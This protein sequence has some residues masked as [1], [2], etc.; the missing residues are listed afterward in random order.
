MFYNDLVIISWDHQRFTSL[1]DAHQL[2]T[3]CLLGRHCFTKHHQPFWI[4]CHWTAHFF[5]LFFSFWYLFDLTKFSF[6]L[7]VLLVPK[8][9][10]FTSRSYNI[11]FKRT[12]QSLNIDGEMHMQASWFYLIDEREDYI[13]LHIFVVLKLIDINTCMWIVLWFVEI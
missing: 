5:L 1:K 10:T 8:I 9:C 6:N 2:W 13:C 7:S 4:L 3:Y 11:K 12:A